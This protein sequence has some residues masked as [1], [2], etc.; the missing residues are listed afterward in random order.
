[1]T[2]KKVVV[3]KTRRGKS[4]SVKG[5][6]LIKK[7]DEKIDSD[8]I[9]NEIIRIGVKKAEKYG[10]IMSFSVVLYELNKKFYNQ[11]SFD[12]FKKNIKK[13]ANK[14][15]IRLIKLENIFHLIQ[16]RP[17]ELEPTMIK[18]LRNPY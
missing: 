17:L 9:I 14:K 7:Y 10:S 1:M 12:K 16:F 2:K 5:K 3:I 13:M 11:I 18:T 6:N 15:L 4:I 8:S